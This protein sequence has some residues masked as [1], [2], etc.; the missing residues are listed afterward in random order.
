MCQGSAQPSPCSLTP[1]PQPLLCCASHL[2]AA[3]AFFNQLG[4]KPGKRPPLWERQQYLIWPA[5]QADQTAAE[6]AL[7]AYSNDYGELGG[8]GRDAVT[9]AQQQRVTWQA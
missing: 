6:E 3:Q 5:T 2:S 8:A 7:A 9:G 1:R 4:T